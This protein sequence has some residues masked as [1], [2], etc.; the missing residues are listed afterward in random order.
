M[1]ARCTGRNE[2][3]SDLT[4]SRSIPDHAPQIESGIPVI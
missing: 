1:S 3:G 4:L 2:R